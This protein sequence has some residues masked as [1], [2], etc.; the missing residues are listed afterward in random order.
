MQQPVP[1]SP[2]FATKSSHIFM[3]SP[4]NFTVVCGID[5]LACKDEF[6]M[7]NSLDVKE[8]V[9]P[10]FSVCPELSMPARH[11]EI[12]IKFNAPR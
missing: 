4:Q 7:N 8:N 3:Q 12:F 10:F 5:C 9:S 2:K 11:T 1:L 6:F